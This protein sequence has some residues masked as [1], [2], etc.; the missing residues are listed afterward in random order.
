[1]IVK[2]EP[3]YLEPMKLLFLM[4]V[5]GHLQRESL[6]FLKFMTLF[7]MRDSDLDKISQAQIDAA[8]FLWDFHVADGHVWHNAQDQGLECLVE[9]VR[10]TLGPRHLRRRKGNCKPLKEKGLQSGPGG[11]RDKQFSGWRSQQHADTVV[12]CWMVHFSFPVMAVCQ[13]C[14]WDLKHAIN[15]VQVWSLLVLEM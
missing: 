8:S 2:T 11:G 3:Q 9:T 7:W 15:L 5:Y 1:M 6:K 10:E 14:W 13:M 12:Y 4:I